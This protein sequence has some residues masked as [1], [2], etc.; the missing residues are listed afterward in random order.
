M[1]VA[2]LTLFLNLCCLLRVYLQILL[3]KCQNVMCVLVEKLLTLAKMSNDI[4]AKVSSQF[5]S[6]HS[7]YSF[8]YSPTTKRDYTSIGIVLSV[9]VCVRLPHYATV[10][11]VFASLFNNKSECCQDFRSKY[12][13]HRHW[14]NEMNEY[15]IIFNALKAFM[16]Q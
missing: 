5:N 15:H 7:A 2:S 4:T 13:L 11:N 12:D 16:D 9:C 6:S 1:S 8:S 10:S 3:H 14:F